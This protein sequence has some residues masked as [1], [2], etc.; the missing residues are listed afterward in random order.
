MT[1]PQ[2]TIRVATLADGAA[3]TEVIAASYGNRLA[4]HYDAAL[5]DRALLIMSKANPVLLNSGKYYVAETSDGEIVGCGGWSLERPGTTDVVP[6]TAHVRHF[7]TDP[8]WTGRGVAR[9]ILSRCIRDAEAQ[10]VQVIDAYST[11]AAVDFYR[12][13]GFVVI[14]P[15]DVP[16]APA[17]TLPS[18]H[19]RWGTN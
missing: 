9:M 11:L 19:M 13:L 6:D 4:A 14:A 17:I 2:F 12:T 18:V 1:D 15:I 7:A 16:L 3:V 10:D 8:R 5:L